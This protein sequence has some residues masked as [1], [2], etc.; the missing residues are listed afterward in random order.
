MDAR[1]LKK[2][3]LFDA[4]DRYQDSIDRPLSFRGVDVRSTVAR[5]V[6]KNPD[7]VT[8]SQILRFEKV[9]TKMLNDAESKV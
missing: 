9:L 5:I 6:D 4:L 7:E 2:Q 8:T 1:E 3:I